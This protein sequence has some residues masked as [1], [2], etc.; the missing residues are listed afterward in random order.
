MD[1]CVYGSQK[2]LEW[3]YF[4]IFEW[5]VLK[6]ISNGG[7]RDFGFSSRSD[8]VKKVLRAA[9]NGKNMRRARYLGRVDV[10]DEICENLKRQ[11]LCFSERLAYLYGGGE[12]SPTEERE[13]DQAGDR[14]E[15]AMSE[16]SNHV[17][18]ALIYQRKKHE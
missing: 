10:S 11:V 3:R 6:E 9:S 14:F 15:D 5:G 13:L 2:G 7:L 8:L 16:L 4:Y 1:V 18:M 12:P 17:H